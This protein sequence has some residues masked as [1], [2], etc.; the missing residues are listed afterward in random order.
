M[1]LG[2]GVHSWASQGGNSQ[3]RATA[4]MTVSTCKVP[5]SFWSSVMLPIWCHVCAWFWGLQKMTMIWAL[6]GKAHLCSSHPGFTQHRSCPG[7]L[8]PIDS[9]SKRHSLCPWDQAECPLHITTICPL[10]SFKRRPLCPLSIE[11][12]GKKKKKAMREV[13]IGQGHAGRKKLHRFSESIQ[14]SLIPKSDPC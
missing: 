13:G 9:R 5:H 11:G 7:Y 6:Q 4:V 8:F 12:R 2:K 10:T 3:L 14:V 1:E